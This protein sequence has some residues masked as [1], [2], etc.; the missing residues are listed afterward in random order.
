MLFAICC[1]HLLLLLFL[2]CCCCWPSSHSAFVDW[3][4]AEK[5]SL[6]KKFKIEMLLGVNNNT[7]NNNNNKNNNQQHDL[8]QRCASFH[9]LSFRFQFKCFYTFL[10]RLFIRTS[11]AAHR[12]LSHF[13]IIL[14]RFQVGM[15]ELSFILR[16]AL[17]Q[18]NS[19]LRAPK[20]IN[21][22]KRSVHM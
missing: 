21:K 8:L 4:V 19:N 17:W 3:C 13:I 1:L 18:L 14:F 11:A 6:G 9:F 20:S 10:L 16:P 22:Y 5:K 7:N 15:L 2:L 12:I